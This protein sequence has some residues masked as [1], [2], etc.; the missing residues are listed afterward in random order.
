MSSPPKYHDDK[1]SFYACD[2]DEFTAEE[3]RK[4]IDDL[5]TRRESPR[6]INLK[7]RDVEFGPAEG[8]RGANTM[9]NRGLPMNTSDQNPFYRNIRPPPPMPRKSPALHELYV[10]YPQCN[11]MNLASSLACIKNAREGGDAKGGNVPRIP[12]PPA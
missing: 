3:K 12:G 11:G 8:L 7:T 9:I 10:K 4:C 1:A 5:I 2:K 6:R